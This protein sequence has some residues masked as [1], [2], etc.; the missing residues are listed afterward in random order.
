MKKND[1]ND[2]LASVKEA[3]QIKKEYD[4]SKGVRG[5]FFKVNATTFSQPL[6]SLKSKQGNATVKT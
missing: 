5:Q 6:N 1:F 3:G 4:F 2:L